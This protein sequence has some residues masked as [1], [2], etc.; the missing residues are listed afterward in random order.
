MPCIP[1][2][3]VSLPT[4]QPSSGCLYL[5]VFAFGEIIDGPSRSARTIYIGQDVQCK[6]AEVCLYG[7]GFV[8]DVMKRQPVTADR[9]YLKTSTKLPA[10]DFPDLIRDVL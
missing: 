2:M 4:N 3:P 1:N 7:V 6:I 9:K 5:A 8:D 10:L